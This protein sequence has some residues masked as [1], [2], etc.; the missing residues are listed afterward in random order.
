MSATAVQ[1]SAGLPCAFI[2]YHFAS[3]LT[4]SLFD[5]H[6]RRQKPA[7]P[8][9]RTRRPQNKRRGGDSRVPVLRNLLTVLDLRVSSFLEGRCAI[10]VVHC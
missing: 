5:Y 7:N 2:L 1:G 3:V 10:P 9:L 4:I 8:K 6:P